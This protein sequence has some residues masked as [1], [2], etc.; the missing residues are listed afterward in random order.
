MTY[1]LT[2]ISADNPRPE[3]RRQFHYGVGLVVGTGENRDIFLCGNRTSAGSEPL[4]AVPAT[5]VRDEADAIARYGRTSEA[6]GMWQGATYWGDGV[7][8]Y[9]GCPTESAGAAAACPLL[10][11]GTSDSVNGWRVDY[12]GYS[13]VYIPPIGATAQQTAEGIRD[14][15]LAAESGT[16]PCTAVSSAVSANHQTLVAYSQRGDRGDAVISNQTDKGLRVTSLGA[17]AQTV[18]KNVAGYVAGGAA[19]NWTA[20]IQA[21][22]DA[23]FFHHAIAKTASVAPTITDNGVGEYLD[24]LK[25]SLTASGNKEQHLTIATIGTVAECIAV[26]TASTVNSVQCDNW[27][28]R[29]SDWPASKLAAH[30]CGYVR[31]MQNQHPSANINGDRLP[32]VPALHR[33]VDR[34]TNGEFIQLLDNGCA[35]VRYGGGGPGA[36]YVERHIHTRYADADGVS[37]KRAREGHIFSAVSFTWDIA[38]QRLK[39]AEQPFVDD[40]PVGTQSDPDATTTPTD[41]EGTL[42]GT[43]KEM[44]KNRPLGRYKGP[45]LRPGAL[46]EMLRDTTAVF[47]P[48]AKIRGVLAAEPVTHRIA[49]E[50]HV[51]Q[52]GLAY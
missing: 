43:I 28:Y 5:P 49:T 32:A 47:A 16:L 36:V 20:M 33:S 13:E 30:M 22:E 45:I 14:M 15:L 10:V 3:T 42:E 21:L 29:G 26:S 48:P 27:C 34:Y 31:M 18:T 50:I 19:D 37:D 6:F 35:P 51:N 9:V 8:I 44:V 12:A 52:L 38:A 4:D 1:P 23:E 17:N 39:A 46:S 41:V 2:G 11:S 40:N 25:T 24:M 7:N